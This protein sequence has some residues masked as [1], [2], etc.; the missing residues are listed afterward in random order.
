M[1]VDLDGRGVE[2][3]RGASPSTLDTSEGVSE[4]GKMLLNCLEHVSQVRVCYLI[5]C[6]RLIF[7]FS[8]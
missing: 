8:L 5:C 3:L 1:L 2:L 4:D 7:S 6:T